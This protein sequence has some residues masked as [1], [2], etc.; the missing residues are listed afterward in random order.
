MTRDNRSRKGIIM[1]DELP[2]WDNDDPL[3]QW[4]PTPGQKARALD[5]WRAYACD[6]PGFARLF[7]DFCNDILVEKD[8]PAKLL[9]ILEHGRL[10]LIGCQGQALTRARMDADVADARGDALRDA[11]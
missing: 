1:T 9:A 5:V 3:E 7:G 11:I 8:L 2:A 6:D 10:S 4:Q